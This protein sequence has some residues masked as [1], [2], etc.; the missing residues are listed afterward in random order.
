MQSIIVPGGEHCANINNMK[1]NDGGYLLSS[2]W[3]L[4]PVRVLRCIC[5]GASV[6]KSSCEE[7]A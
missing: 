5:H 3:G 7:K 1:A 6:Q 4:G 2:C